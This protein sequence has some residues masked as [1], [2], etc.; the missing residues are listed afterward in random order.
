MNRIKFPIGDWSNDGHGKCD[1]FLVDSNKTVQ[2]VREAHFLMKEKLGISIEDI[3]QDYEE[4]EIFGPQ[5]K[6]F[7]E[8]G[9]IN[10]VS[11]HE[12]DNVYYIEDSHEMI[13][14]WVALLKCVDPTLELTIVD[15]LVPTIN[16]YGVDEKKR[17][18]GFVG[19]G[20]FV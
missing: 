15:D 9:L 5:A 17:H 2:A 18:I 8:L 11:Y 13:N 4:N 1:W 10:L 3:A 19:Y 7:G 16:F 20:I 12:E 6:I 14:L